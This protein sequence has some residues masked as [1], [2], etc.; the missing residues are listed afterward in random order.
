M[1]VVC[2]YYAILCKG[3]EQHWILSSLG[4]WFQELPPPWILS[5]DC[6]NNN[7][8]KL[9]IVANNYYWH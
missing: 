4:D 7:N 9:F 8:N 2:K 1:H 3:L 5:E 6:N